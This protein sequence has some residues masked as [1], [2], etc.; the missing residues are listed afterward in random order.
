MILRRKYTYD[1]LDYYTIGKM[2]TFERNLQKIYNKTR[3]ILTEINIYKCFCEKVQNILQLIFKTI[4][5]TLYF[6]ISEI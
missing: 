1:L 2:F 4:Y 3:M 6:Y 5:Y